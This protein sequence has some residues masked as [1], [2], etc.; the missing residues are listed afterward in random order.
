MTSIFNRINESSH[1][2]LLFY[3]SP[4]QLTFVLS[5]SY[6]ITLPALKQFGQYVNFFFFPF[7]ISC[8]SHTVISTILHFERTRVYCSSTR[9]NQ[10]IWGYDYLLILWHVFF[11]LF[12]FWFP[13]NISA[14]RRNYGSSIWEKKERRKSLIVGF[15]PMT[16]WFWVRCSVGQ[17]MQGVVTWKPKKKLSSIYIYIYE[18]KQQ[19][20]GIIKYF[21]PLFIK[22]YN[23]TILF[24]FIILQNKIY[25]SIEVSNIQ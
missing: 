5:K 20:T 24:Y 3:F 25:I 14:K 1:I 17:A 21:F 7:F 18:R 12:F 9:T 11:V 23:F 10:K 8:F 15:N 2:L 6:L 4:S 16:F 13:S 19:H 22:T